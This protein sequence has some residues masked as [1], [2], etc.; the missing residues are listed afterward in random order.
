MQ[1]EYNPFKDSSQNLKT[2][3][4]GKN[5]ICPEEI[6]DIKKSISYYNG[7]YIYKKGDRIIPLE[8]L[9]VL[10]KYIGL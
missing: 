6:I 9:T 5:S 1:Y 10:R 4:I 8:Y 3:T 2:P 7:D